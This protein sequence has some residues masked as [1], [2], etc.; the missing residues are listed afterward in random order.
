MFHLGA[1]LREAAAQETMTGCKGLSTGGFKRLVLICFWFGCI[2]EALSHDRLH[3]G[4]EAKKGDPETEMV[5]PP[6]DLLFSKLEPA[7]V[8]G[9]LVQHVKIQERGE[10]KSGTGF[11]FSWAGGTLI[12]TCRYLQSAFGEESCTVEVASAETNRHGGLGISNRTLV[13]EPALGQHDARCS[14]DNVERVTIAISR[15]QKH[16]LPVSSNC[17][18]SHPAGIDART[19]LGPDG[20]QSDGYACTFK[21]GSAV[22]NHDDLWRCVHEAA[23]PINDDWHQMAIF[24]DP[25]P[26]AVSA[27][28]HLNR[29]R[30]LSFYSGNVDDFVTVVLPTMTQ[31]VAVRHILFEGILKGRST[32]FWYDDAL[33]NPRQWHDRWMQTIGVQLPSVV[34]QGMADAALTGDLG[35]SLIHI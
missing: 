7:G 12:Q 5:C 13:F 15:H 28:Y 29:N 16:M 6:C 8:E 24:R 9:K 23:C 35:L 10:P 34:V 20:K 27:F 30:K 32:A 2:G 26:V 14:C 22:V 31:W 17:M 33:N 1:D 11:M 3:K 18:Y 19:L 25:R 21:D 4:V